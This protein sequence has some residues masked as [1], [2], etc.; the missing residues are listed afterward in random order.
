M[1]KAPPIKVLQR[2]DGIAIRAVVQGKAQA[3]AQVAQG[4]AQILQLRAQLR[5]AEKE[6]A[7]SFTA[8]GLDVAL[9]GRYRFEG[10]DGGLVEVYLEDAPE[11]EGGDDG[12]A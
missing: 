9:T 10:V 8:A 11:A 3:A 7:A 6:E 4:E 12:D 2:N 5:A 1:T